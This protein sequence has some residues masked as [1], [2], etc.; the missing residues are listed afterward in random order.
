MC[1]H[2]YSLI[3][4]AEISIAIAEQVV[5]LMNQEVAKSEYHDKC[6]QIT[7]D[8]EKTAKLHIQEF[9]PQASRRIFRSSLKVLPS[10]G[11]YDAFAEVI[12]L[13]IFNIVFLLSKNA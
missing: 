5:A 9:D 8:R 4:N 3:E 10:G 6:A 7:V 12:I 1:Q 11:L 13:K 2:N